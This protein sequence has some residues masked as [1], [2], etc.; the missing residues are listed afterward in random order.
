MFDAIGRELGLPFVAEDLGRI[1]PP[2]ERL[3]DELG[4]PGML[5]L[6]FGFEPDV[7]RSVHRLAN[8]VEH[9][10]VYTGTH[11]HD[12]ARGFIEALDPARRA[13]FDAELA[14]RGIVEPRQPWWGLIR[15][16]MSSPARVAMLQ[17]Q[18][19][20]GLGSEAR[21]N[22]PASAGGNWR[23]RLERGALTARL[24]RRLRDGDRGGRPPRKR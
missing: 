8:H 20:L 17:A 7:P 21:M 2:V 5:V 13:V 1:T 4:L 24:A 9:R 15:L 19:V 10:F 23:W 12:T 22:D 6:Q 16:A 3:R 14:A 18:D 11:D